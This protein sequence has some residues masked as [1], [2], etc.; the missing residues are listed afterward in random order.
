MKKVNVTVSYD[1]EKLNAVRL[2]LEH[3]NL[4]LEDELTAIIDS[5]F[6]KH[7]PAGVREY[8]E[9]RDGANTVRP[10]KKAA[11]LLKA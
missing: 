2:F 4:K 1:E 7:V 8:L 11:E 10:P 3:K 6:K 5:L 9:L